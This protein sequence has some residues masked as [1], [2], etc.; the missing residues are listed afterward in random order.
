[1]R[2]VTLLVFAVLSML[3]LAAAAQSQERAKPKGTEV[4]DTVPSPSKVKAGQP[5]IEPVVTTRQAGGDTI[6]EYRLK[7][8][9]YKQVVKPSK[10]PVYTLIDE[11]G[12]GKFTRVD[13]PDAKIAVPMW[14]LI[15]W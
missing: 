6:Q 7:G 13:G 11:K 2:Q 15:D 8:R 5:L 12:E 10:G 3:P 9:L 4:I 1:M 14:V